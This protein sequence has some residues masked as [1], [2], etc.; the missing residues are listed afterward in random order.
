MGA[1][2]SLQRVLIADPRVAADNCV[3]QRVQEFAVH[4]VLLEQQYLE[5]GIKRAVKR[6]KRPVS[7][8]AKEVED[9]GDGADAATTEEVDR[10]E[11]HAD[12][13]NRSKCSS[14]VDEVFLLLRKS[15]V[16]GVHSTISSSLHLPGSHAT[17]A[18]L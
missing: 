4:Y 11:L 10:E 13:E 5:V 15:S 17:K 3:A 14:M 12:A 8:Q 16:R 6:D 1:L 7:A 9:D 2:V 18:T